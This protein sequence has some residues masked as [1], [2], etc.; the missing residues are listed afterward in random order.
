MGVKDEEINKVTVSNAQQYKQAGNSIVISVLMAI[1][2]ELLDI[3][4]ETKIKQIYD[5][6]NN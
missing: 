4:Y 5:Y 2:G 1:F 3:D 6:Q